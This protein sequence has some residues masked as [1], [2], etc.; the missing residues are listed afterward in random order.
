MYPTGYTKR[1]LEIHEYV[2]E[3][4]RAPYSEWLGSLDRPVKVRV[5]TRVDRVRRGLLGDCRSVGGG[6]FELRLDFGSGYRVYFGQQ[7]DAI[8][9]LLCGG[10]KDSQADDIKKAKGYWHA[11]NLRRTEHHEKDES[12]QRDAKGGT[13]RPA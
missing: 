5:I 1:V 10:D 7:G 12:I 6:V 8:V 11:L 13:T 4:K 2:T 9:V 3:N